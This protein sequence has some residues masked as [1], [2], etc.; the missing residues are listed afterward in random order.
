MTLPFVYIKSSLYFYFFADFFVAFL[1]TF[2]AVVLRAVFFLL[3]AFVFCFIGR[4]QHQRVVLETPAS[5]ITISLA[6]GTHTSSCPFFKFAIFYPLLIF[7]LLIV[8]RK[9]MRVNLFLAAQ[10][11]M[12]SRMK[13]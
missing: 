10:H 8:Y 13:H 3:A 4:P 5:L 6:Q 9:H 2:F 12:T 7:S 11:S 1:A